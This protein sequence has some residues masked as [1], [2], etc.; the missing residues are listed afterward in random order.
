MTTSA[1]DLELEADPAN[2]S[3]IPTDP[4]PAPRPHLARCGTCGKGVTFEPLPSGHGFTIR[5]YHGVSQDTTFSVGPTGFPVCPDDGHGEMQLADE[6]LPAAEAFAVAQEKLAAGPL[7]EQQRLPGVVLP[8]NFQ[9]AYLELEA[10][11]VEVDRL[12]DEYKAA[13]E[14]ARGAKKDW[15][16]AAELYTKMALELRRRR[17]AK[18][19]QPAEDLLDESEREPSTNLV[20]GCK[21][22]ERHQNEICPACADVKYAKRYFNDDLAPRDSERHVEQVDGWLLDREVNGVIDALDDLDIVVTSPLVCGWSSEDRAAVTAWANASVEAANDPSITIPA[23]PK[24]LGTGHVAG[25]GR[26]GE[27]QCCTQCDAVLIAAGDDANYYET[28]VLVGTECKG[29]PPAR[30]AEPRKKGGRK[31]PAAE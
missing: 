24:V 25:E 14:E 3:P 4:P 21:W 17:R 1:D 10:K 20:T 27:A 28:G 15:D 30:Y 16:K 29:K 19:G 6:Q 26:D 12:H 22:E 9:G 7:A 23:R 31:K 18:E 8:F 2:D 11:A 13:A 5:A